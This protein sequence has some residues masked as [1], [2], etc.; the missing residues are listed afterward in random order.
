MRRELEGLEGAGVE[1][2]HVAAADGLC[3][4]NACL[5][6]SPKRVSTLMDISLYTVRILFIRV[7]MRIE[8][9]LSAVVLVKVNGFF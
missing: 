4:W 2:G 6:F 1:V 8:C 5:G 9:R 7:E 3:G